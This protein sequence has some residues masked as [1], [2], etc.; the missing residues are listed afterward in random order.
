M[1]F[2]SRLWVRNLTLGV[3][4]QF[5]SLTTILLVY[6]WIRFERFTQYMGAY[7]PKA[8]LTNP[9]HVSWITNHYLKTDVYPLYWWIPATMIVTYFF[10]KVYARY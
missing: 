4:Y 6:G 7:Y 1:S 3:L 9:A 8:D 2:R 10:K 5:F